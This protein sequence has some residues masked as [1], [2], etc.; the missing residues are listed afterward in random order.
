[1]ILK[2][3]GIYC[4]FSFTHLISLAPSTHSNHLMLPHIP[5]MNRI[6][7]KLIRSSCQESDEI[8]D[9]KVGR[10]SRAIRFKIHK[11]LV[12][13]Y[14]DYFKRASESKFLESI[15]GRFGLD[16]D[17]VAFTLFVEWL[18]SPK[19]T[20]R[21]SQWNAELKVNSRSFPYVSR[22]KNDNNR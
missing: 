12:C 14:S 3:K 9:V 18:Y 6:E 19:K 7:I 16:E 5:N 11:R 17:P 21:S 1:M 10:G 22:T 8:V 2:M 15:T 20:P 13:R 4:Q